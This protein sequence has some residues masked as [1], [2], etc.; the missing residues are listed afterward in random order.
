MRPASRERRHKAGQ[1]LLGGS[2]LLML[3][4][5][6]L[7]Q[8]V[9]LAGLS[10]NRALLVIE[11]ASP[12]FMSPGQTSQGVKLVSAQGDVAVIE[13]E[14]RRQ[15]LR[16]GDAPVHVG[17]RAVVGGQRIVLTADASGHFL[18]QGQINGR[19][20][21]FMVDTGA[22]LIAI[23]ESEA[24]RLNLNFETGRPVRI[25]TANGT[26]NAYQIQLS[27][28]RVGDVQVYDVAAVVAPQ[29]M[30]FVLL[31]NSFLTRFQMQRQNDQMTLEKR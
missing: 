8:Q 22:T 19:S 24:R 16:V 20:V 28:V 4:G 9:A 15:I 1:W 3:A 10:A 29:P 17:G 14:G 31:G 11:G 5:P 6:A 25:S 27:S 23:S 21:Q 18:P 30:P 7:A 12:R 26:V 2:L 13:V